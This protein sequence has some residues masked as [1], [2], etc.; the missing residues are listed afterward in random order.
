MIFANCYKYYPTDHDVV[1]MAGKLQ[2]VF[3]VRYAKI[4]DDLTESSPADEGSD[5]SEDD[6][7]EERAKKLLLLQVQVRLRF[8]GPHL[9]LILKLSLI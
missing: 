5:H 6:S 1:A 8:S 7:E 9:G 3:E 4:P 2:H